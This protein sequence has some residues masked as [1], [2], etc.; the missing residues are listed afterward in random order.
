M[1][2]SQDEIKPVVKDALTSTGRDFIRFIIS[3]LAPFVLILLGAG[4]AALGLSQGWA[5]S[6]WAGLIIAG[7]GLIWGIFLFMIATA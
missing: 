1:L 2:D 4:L 3:L 5:F 7:I 6:L